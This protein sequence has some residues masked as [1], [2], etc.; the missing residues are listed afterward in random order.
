MITGKNILRILSL[1]LFINGIAYS[2]SYLFDSTRYLD[3]PLNQ[4]HAVG[5]SLLKDQLTGLNLME[6]EDKIIKEVLSGN[7]PSFSRRL[8]PIKISEVF[9]SSEFELIIFVTSDYMA[10]GSDEDYLYV[11]MT[12]GTAQILADTLHCMLPTKKMVDIIYNKATT[13]LR[14]Q[15]IPPS[16]EMITVPVFWQHSDSVKHQL[17]QKGI[18]RDDN[19]LMAGHKKDIIISNKIYSRDWDYSRV[20]IYGWHKLDGNPIQPVYNRHLDTWADY[21]HG[22]RLISKT[23]LLNGKPVSIDKIL[24]DEMMSGLI[25]DEG[26]IGKPFY[27][28]GMRN[29]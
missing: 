9:N 29:K 25:S 1:V 6:R 16:E 2:Q 22:V 13:K 23:A 28:T 10:I 8:I 18:E 17:Q 21:S 14:P 7:V 3:L 4:E 11:P 24:N 19:K 15:P 27:P 5:G 20:V 12:P 26:K